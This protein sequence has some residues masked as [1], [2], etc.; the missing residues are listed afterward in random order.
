M[1]TDS[2]GVV[3]YVDAP[4]YFQLLMVDQPITEAT[5]VATAL[6][7]ALAGLFTH[8]ENAPRRRAGTS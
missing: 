2:S 1:A 3:E 7:A 5:R 6:V 4:I 8:P